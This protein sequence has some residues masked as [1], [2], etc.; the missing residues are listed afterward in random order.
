[1]GEAEVEVREE[2]G[3]AQTAMETGEEE[4]GEHCLLF[5]FILFSLICL[6][7]CAFSF[8]RADLGGRRLGSPGL[9]L[10]EMRAGFGLCV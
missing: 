8:C 3:P 10:I 1:M 5:Y 2:G 4:A 6:L 9:P 7:W